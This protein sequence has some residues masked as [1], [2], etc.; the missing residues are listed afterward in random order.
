MTTAFRK[1]VCDYYKLERAA[2]KADLVRSYNLAIAF[3]PEGA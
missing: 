3:K 1:S 2:L